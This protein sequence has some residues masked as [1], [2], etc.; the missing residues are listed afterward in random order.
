MHLLLDKS[1]YRLAAA[2]GDDL[3]DHVIETM[4]IDVVTDRVTFDELVVW[5][6][7]RI[8]PRPLPTQA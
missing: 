6:K 2:T 3:L 5:F 1:G 7:A 4:V 8:E